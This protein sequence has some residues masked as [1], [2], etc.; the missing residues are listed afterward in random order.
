MS[1]NN[2]F[3]I[4]LTMRVI[5]T[6]EYKET[7]DAISHDWIRFLSAEQCQILLVP[8]LPGNAVEFLRSQKPD[9]V[10][11]SSGNDIGPLPG[12][13][14]ATASFS[15]ERDQTEAKIV[16]LC[17]EK[18]LPILG[19]CRGMQMLNIFF[20]GSLIRDLGNLTDSFTEHAGNTHSIESLDPVFFKWCGAK[21]QTNSY[22][23]QGVT[24][25]TLAPGLR[26]LATCGPVIEAIAHTSLPFVGIQWHPER[27][28]SAACID[29]HLLTSL[30]NGFIDLIGGT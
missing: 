16:E 19:V 6:A 7:R 8:N 12:E 13:L 24:N 3:R 18:Q 1:I 9:A 5:E 2:K 26:A 29:K 20:G 15:I 27:S 14:K 25:Q 17:I 11:L 10:I 22:H 28:Y 23:R 30:K 4:A 21:S